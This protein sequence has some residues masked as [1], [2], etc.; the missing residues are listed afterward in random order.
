[1]H[2]GATLEDMCM[3]R[4]TDSSLHF[5]VDQLNGA[6]AFCF[7]LYATD[8]LPQKLIGWNNASLPPVLLARSYRVGDKI[9]FSEDREEDIREY[10][11]NQ[12]DSKR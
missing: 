3:P 10:L 5:E 11:R 2:P 8:K 9:P 4:A 1:M 7:G 12:V 6:K